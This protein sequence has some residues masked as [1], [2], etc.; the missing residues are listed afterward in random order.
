MEPQEKTKELVLKYFHSWQNPADFDE[1]GGYLAEDI[2]FD[3]NGHQ[4][5]GVEAV[6][7]MLMQNPTPWKE[8][9]LLDAVF[10]SDQAVLVYQGVN[11]ATNQK[12]RVAEHLHLANLQITKVTAVLSI[13]PD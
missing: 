7:G 11:T 12:I 6:I 9:Q 8:V 2:V 1:M 4:L 3:R 10:S 5:Q 13:L